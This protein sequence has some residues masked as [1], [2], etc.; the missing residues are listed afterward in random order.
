VTGNL[1]IDEVHRPRTGPVAAPET[2]LGRY[3]QDRRL[4]SHST[5]TATRTSRAER[6][7]SNELLAEIDAP[8]EATRLDPFVEPNLCVVQLASRPQPTRVRTRQ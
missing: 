6:A 7:G 3:F 8:L 4:E 1:A 2:R 5:A